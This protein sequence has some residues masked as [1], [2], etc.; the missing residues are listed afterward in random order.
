MT[1]MLVLIMLSVALGCVG[2]AVFLW[3]LRSGQ[4]D[5]LKGSA[6]RVLFDEPPGPPA[7]RE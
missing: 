6:S 3:S 2:L 7:R 1:A 5:D 4:Y